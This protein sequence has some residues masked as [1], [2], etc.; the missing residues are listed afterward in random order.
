GPDVGL[1]THVADI[2]G[3]L[4]FEDLRRVMLVGHSYGGMVATAV[5]DRA[6]DR[7][8]QLV[9]LDA[10]VPQNGQCLFDLE[11]EEIRTRMRDAART[12]GDGW[13][14]P[15]N[16]MPPD[17]SEADLAWAVPRRVMQ[18][19]KTF[20]QRVQLTGEGERLPKTYI[21]CTRPAPGDVFGQFARRAQSE[22]GWHFFEIDSS[23]NP[24]ITTPEVLA[25]LLDK[26]AAERP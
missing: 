19:L 13:R 5:A 8:E 16:P 14:V 18:P 22:P 20:E 15:P 11:P 6:P 24:H 2:L 12:A 4:Q 9:Y 17:T 25:H 23:H 7:L 21:Y 1:E 26:V 10:F 3:V